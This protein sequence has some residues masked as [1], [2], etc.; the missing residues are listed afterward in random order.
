MGV[1]NTV[2]TKLDNVAILRT[3]ANEVRILFDRDQ[4]VD[5]LEG[6]V[7]GGLIPQMG[8]AIMDALAQVKSSY[9]VDPK[10]GEVTAVHYTRMD[11]VIGMF[12]ARI[13]GKSSYLRMYDTF[14]S[15][16]PDEGRYLTSR[17][18]PSTSME[19]TRE[20]GDAPSCAYVT[21]FVRPKTEKE[22]DVRDVMDN[23]VFWRTYGDDGT[24]CSLTVKVPADGLLKV[25]Y[26]RKAAEDAGRDVLTAVREVRILMEW[27]LRPIL[28][29]PDGSAQT[30][31]TDLRKS[32][33]SELRKSISP[34]FYS[35]KSEAYRYEQ[36]VRAIATIP[37]I[38]RDQIVFEYP[39][40]SGKIDVRHYYE[41]DDLRVTNLLTTGSVITIGPCVQNRE[42]VA[43]YL[44]HLKRK[45]N[46]LGPQV[47]QSQVSYRNS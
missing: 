42:N 7:Q 10:I 16:D 37:I 22:T 8:K 5:T 24:G 14:H 32:L 25:S 6:R 30:I 17:S 2:D 23:L 34:I 19:L 9:L 31:L 38:E 35:H 33:V 44:E 47:V 26:G 29:I 40:D 20:L 39:N 4:N 15:N 11:V 12:Q 43:Y 45:S 1:T 46:L 41:R 18:A 36:E 21:A 3:M 28:D 13:E 27:S